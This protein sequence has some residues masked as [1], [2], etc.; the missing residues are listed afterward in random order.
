MVALIQLG[1]DCWN[2]LETALA[3]TNR[4]VARITL[5]DF[6][7]LYPYLV[8]LKVKISHYISGQALRAS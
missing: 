1:A 2:I 6:D 5:L 7:R 4:Q 3:H 8:I